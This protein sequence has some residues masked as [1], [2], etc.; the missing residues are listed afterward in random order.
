MLLAVSQA[1]KLLKT[2]VSTRYDMS[3]A[4]AIQQEYGVCVNC[5]KPFEEVMGLCRACGTERP[6]TK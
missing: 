5:N 4:S 1:L 2:I 6:E 3:F